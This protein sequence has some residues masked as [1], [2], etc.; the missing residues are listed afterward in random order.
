M[1]KEV[2]VFSCIYHLKSIRTPAKLRAIQG[3]LSFS[4]DSLRQK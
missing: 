1:L 2:T 4:D 3:K